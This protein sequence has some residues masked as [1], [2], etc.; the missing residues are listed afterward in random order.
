[1]GGRL[2]P[3]NIFVIL[4]LLP[5]IIKFILIFQFHPWSSFSFSSSLWSWTFSWSSLWSHWWSGYILKIKMFWWSCYLDYLS[6]LMIKISGWFQ[7]LDDQD[8][9]MIKI[10]LNQSI[11]LSI[12]SELGSIV[13]S[14]S[15]NLI[16]FPPWLPTHNDVDDDIMTSSWYSFYKKVIC[17]F[18]I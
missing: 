3:D 5:H 13:M 9:L 1:M 11:P 4:L 15:D 10:S 14:C 6:I 17:M 7:Y 2:A 18:L 8:I 16:T 12:S